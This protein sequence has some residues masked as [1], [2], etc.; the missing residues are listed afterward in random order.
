VLGTV[1]GAA[2]GGEI[3]AWGLRYFDP[4]LPG[5][6]D[7]TNDI[8]TQ[9]SNVCFKLVSERGTVFNTAN[10]IRRGWKPFKAIFVGGERLYLYVWNLQSNAVQFNIEVTL[11]IEPLGRIEELLYGKI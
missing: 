10:I 8:G 11:N 6:T 1:A 7:V 2:D 3:E 9:F 4:G 5:F